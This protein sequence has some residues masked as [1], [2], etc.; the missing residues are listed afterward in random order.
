MCAGS[1][2]SRFAYTSNMGKPVEFLAWHDYR[3]GIYRQQERELA[4]TEFL[5]LIIGLLICVL[6]AVGVIRPTN[7]VAMVRDSLKTG[8][9]D[10]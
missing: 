9:V 10:A 6:C 4:I 1:E 2:W 7:L 8:L 3:I 5:V